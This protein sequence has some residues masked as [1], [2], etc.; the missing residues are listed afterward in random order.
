MEIPKEVKAKVAIVNKDGDIL[1]LRRSQNEE[2]RRGESDWAGGTVDEG[3]TVRQG[4]LREVGEELPGTELVEGTI[5]PIYTKSKIKNEVAVTTEL[6]AAVARYPEG[7]IVLG[8]EHDLAEDLPV[9]NY[10]DLVMPNKYKTA[11][12]IGEP[13]IRYLAELQQ[14]GRLEPEPVLLG[15]R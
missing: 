3:E 11:V 2:T 4:L 5:I 12:M 6:F 10:P 7:G 13:V 15:N 1:T 8:E 9:E 14:T